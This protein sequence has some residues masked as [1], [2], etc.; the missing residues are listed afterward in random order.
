MVEYS[1]GGLLN[2][3]IY[4]NNKKK[5]EEIDKGLLGEGYQYDIDGK[6]Y[7]F[8]EKMPRGFATQQNFLNDPAY[9][10]SLI[11]I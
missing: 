5:K 1:F 2:K 6:T 11:H 9:Q 10:L 4:A 3:N 8:D 7:G